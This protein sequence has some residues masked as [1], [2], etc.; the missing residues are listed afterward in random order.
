MAMI[1]AFATPASG[2]VG[3]RD[4]VP[5]PKPRFDVDLASSSFPHFAR[6]L[7]TGGDNATE[8]ASVVAENRIYHDRDHPSHVIL[9][10]VR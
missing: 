8:T 7:N 9:P 1:A 2:Q 3:E 4:V 5:F 6:N 10:V